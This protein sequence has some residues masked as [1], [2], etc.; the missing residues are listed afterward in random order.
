M[1]YI[2]DEVSTF[3]HLYED[4]DIL[5]T[6]EVA[7]VFMQGA[8]IHTTVK[9]KLTLSK[10]RKFKGLWPHIVGF[11]HNIG[12]YN[13]YALPTDEMAEKWEKHFYFVDTGV[14]YEGQKIMKYKD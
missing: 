14:T 9:S 7:P 12:V 6:F 11:L 3:H 5:V 13:I 4:E 8:F 1:E 2:N 10:W